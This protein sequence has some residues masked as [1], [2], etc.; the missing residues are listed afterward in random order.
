MMAAPGIA[1]KSPAI[2]WG[3]NWRALHGERECGDLHVVAPFDGGVLVGAVDGLGH[4]P[5]AAIAARTAVDTLRVHAQEPI[6][7]L[8]E[9]CHEALRQ[10]RGAVLS[11]ASIDA[12]ASTIAWTAVGNVQAI[13]YS[14]NRA[15]RPGR[16]ILNARSGVVGYQLPPLRASTL[17]IAAGDTLV[18]ATDGISESFCNEMPMDCGPQEAADRILRRFGKDN[19][20]ALALVVRWLGAP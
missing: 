10:T 4:G 1:A 20:D 11:V 12:T 16:E 18:F 7:R 17:P 9:R 8:V 3:V 2:D 19:D 15:L 5:E 13:L 14:A 6:L